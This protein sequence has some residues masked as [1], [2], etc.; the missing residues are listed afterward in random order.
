MRISR[1]PTALAAATALLLLLGA[2]AARAA[3]QAPGVSGA[4]APPPPSNFNKAVAA[5]QGAASGS[6]G[7]TLKLRAEATYKVGGTA[8]GGSVTITNPGSSPVYIFNAPEVIVKSVVPKSQA[9]SPAAKALLSNDREGALRQYRPYNGPVYGSGGFDYI[10]AIDEAAIPGCFAGASLADG[11]G[12]PLAAGK[13]VTCKFSVPAAVIAGTD[14]KAVVV[15]LER[16]T[17]AKGAAAARAGA[18]G[19]CSALALVKTA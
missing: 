10:L 1:A 3:A 5:I 13:S 8:V 15:S 6:D 12:V 18:Y 4:K 2:P 17:T 7:C 9:A 16:L 14:P 19:S 11:K